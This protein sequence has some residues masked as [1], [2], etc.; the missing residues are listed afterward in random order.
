MLSC[1]IGMVDKTKRALAVLQERSVHD[2]EELS[3][4]MRRQA[5]GMDQDTRKRTNDMMAHTIR[6]TEDRVSEVRRRAGMC[7][8]WNMMKFII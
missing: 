2:R 4:W 1:I 6:Q 3:M 7:F 8:I 5:E